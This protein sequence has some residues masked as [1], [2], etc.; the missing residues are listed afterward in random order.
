MVLIVPAKGA[1]KHAKV[2]PGITDAFHNFVQHSQQGVWLLI[3]V[4]Q[5][6]GAD[7]IGGL[8]KT[9]AIPAITTVNEIL[10]TWT[11]V[12]YLAKP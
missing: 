12:P 4:I 9:C 10:Y 7:G 1:E 3:Q 8:L 5:V 2:Q 6:P 11:A